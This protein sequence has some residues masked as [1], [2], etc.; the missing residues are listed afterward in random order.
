M[1][2]TCSINCSCLSALC[3]S[4]VGGGGGAWAVYMGVGVVGV[5]VAGEW[6]Q[7]LLVLT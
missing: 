3:V 5:C 6:V 4:S 7:V 1:G 2:K